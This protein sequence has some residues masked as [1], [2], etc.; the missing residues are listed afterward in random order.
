MCKFKKAI[1]V[2]LSAV[3]MLS[4]GSMPIAV[5]ASEIKSTEYVKVESGNYNGFIYLLFDGIDPSIIQYVGTDTNIVIP[6][7]INGMVVNVSGEAF[8]RLDITSV[9][10][11]DCINF[12]PMH[13]FYQCEKLKTIDFGNSVETIDIYAFSGCTS[14]ESIIIPD[15]VK[16]INNEAFSNCSGL[17]SVKLGN[18]IYSLGDRAFANCT[19]LESI[20]IPEEIKYISN[21]AFLGCEKL[22]I[23][24]YKDSYAETYA[25]KNDIQFIAFYVK[26]DIDLD[27]EVTIQDVTLMQRYCADEIETIEAPVNYVDVDGNDSID[28]NDATAIQRLL[29]E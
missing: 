16:A 18:G 4:A 14:L 5:N 13:C 11:P 17:K 21:S 3:M 22:T 19:N 29:V 28:I 9:E 27:G 8:M 23:Y 6:S 15:S 2:M 1:V 10:I 25:K 12:I 24:G 7:E 20:V 26:G